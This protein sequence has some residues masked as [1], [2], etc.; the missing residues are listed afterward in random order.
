MKCFTAGIPE[1]MSETK[2]QLNKNNYMKK[3]FELITIPIAIVL[4]LIYNWVAEWFGLFTFTWEMFGKVFVAFL[5]F[6]VSIGFVRLVYIFLFPAMYKYFDESFNHHK[7]VWNIL[8]EK[9]RL[10]YSVALFAS[11]L[12]FFGLIV[13]GL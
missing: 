3:Y 1:R 6:L 5:M 10:F 4:L 8:S 11:M 9:E 7:S 12:L 2:K 13:N